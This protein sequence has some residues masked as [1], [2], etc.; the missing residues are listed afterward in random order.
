MGD[1]LGQGAFARSKIGN[2]IV[3]ENLEHRFGK[4]FPGTAGNVFAAKFSGEFVK[5]GSDLV[6]PFPEDVPEG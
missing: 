2:S 4:P 6:F 1:Q 3:V 5:I